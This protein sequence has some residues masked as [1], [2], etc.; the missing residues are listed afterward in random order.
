MIN[1]TLIWVGRSKKDLAKF[2]VEAQE[3]IADQLMHFL[4]MKKPKDAKP[5]KGLK[6]VFEI[7]LKHNKEAY[8]CVLAVQIGNDIY[9]LHAF[10][11]KSK[12]GIA[13]PQEDIK[14][15]KQRYKLAM[16]IE[17]EKRK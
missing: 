15:I 4:D 16:E 14:L 2:P 9:V 8:R 11:K 13:T 10:H 12:S 5:F 7:A 3:I 1:R 6:G 17:N